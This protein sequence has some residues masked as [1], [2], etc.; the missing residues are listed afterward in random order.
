MIL[1]IFEAIMTYKRIIYYSVRKK[2]SIVIQM[3][4]ETCFNFQSIQIRKMHF[5]LLC[6][7]R[8]KTHLFIGIMMNDE[9]LFCVLIYTIGLVWSEFNAVHFS[10]LRKVQKINKKAQLSCARLL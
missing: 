4:N 6:R 3:F 5:S 9:F 1:N 10:E 8:W 2:Y 7:K